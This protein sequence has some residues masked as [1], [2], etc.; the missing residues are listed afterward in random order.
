V[1][2]SKD[3]LTSDSEEDEEEEEENVTKDDYVML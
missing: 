3:F 2:A 1:E